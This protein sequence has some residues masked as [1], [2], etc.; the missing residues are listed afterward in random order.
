VILALAA[1]LVLALSVPAI[2]GNGFPFGLAKQANRKA[3]KA[4]NTARGARKQVNRLRSRVNSAAT[5]FSVQA[6]T[7]QDAPAS[8][9]GDLGGPRVQVEVPV[10][11]LIEVWAQVTMDDDGAV[12]LFEDGQKMPGQG[13]F[14]DPEGALFYSAGL[15]SGTGEPL[16]LGT[17][18]TPGL[19]ACAT[20]GPPGP[21]LFQTTPGTHGYELRYQ[22]CSCGGGEVHFSDRKLFVGPLP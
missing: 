11:G 9:Y 17:P 21:V 19:A 1:V 22:D 14:C 13:K 7:V 12:A 6:G 8:G 3:G 10:S 18:G 16:A 4:L 15:V 20:E 2:G 5:G